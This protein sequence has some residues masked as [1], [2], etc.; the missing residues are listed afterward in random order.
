M[1]KVEKCNNE[2]TTMPVQLYVDGFLYYN[3]QLKYVTKVDI[4]NRVYSEPGNKRNFCD[5][6]DLPKTS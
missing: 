1:K 6:K 4:L 3:I 2:S 5:N